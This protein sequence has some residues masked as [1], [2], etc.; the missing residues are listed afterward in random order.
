MGLYKKIKRRPVEALKVITL[1]GFALVF[2]YFATPSPLTFVIG[3]PLIL[4]GVFIRCW[5]AG[6]LQRN[7]QLATSGPYAYVRDSLY[8]GRLF[9]LSQSFYWLD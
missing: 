9:L 5:A 2:V 8:L 4:M 7:R 3:L 6:H 1:W